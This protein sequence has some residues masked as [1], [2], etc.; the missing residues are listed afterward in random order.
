MPTNPVLTRLLNLSGVSGD[1]SRVTTFILDYVLKRGKD[2]KVTPEIHFGKNLQDNL[3][4]VFGKP[5]TAVFAHMDTVG[6]MAR[7]ENQLVPIGG[8]EVLDGDV[9][10]GE[11]SYGFIECCLRLDDGNL[12]HDFDRYILPGTILTYRQELKVTGEYIQGAY[13]DNRLG[14]F[15]A[16]QLCEELTDGVVVFSTYEEHG[17][18]AVPLLMKYIYERWPIQQA[19]ISDITWVTEGVRPGDGVVISVRD[20]HI[21]R[22]SFLDTIIRLANESGVP[23]QLEVEAYGSSDGREVH[24]AP[25]PVDWCFIGAPE[26]NAHTPR[27]RVTWDDLDAMLRMYRFLMA[28]L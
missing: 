12:Y 26:E 4:L 23:F 25:Y 21:P 16:L 1:E 27:E 14:V 8:P 9:L 3:I 5:R 24:Y 19:L 7:Y 11:D 13:L 15:N 28:H 2:W 17:G 18:G 10:V 22:R 20:K 6:F